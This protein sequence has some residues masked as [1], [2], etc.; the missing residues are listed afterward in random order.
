VNLNARSGRGSNDAAMQVLKPGTKITV[1]KRAGSWA[2]IRTTE[3][4]LLCSTAI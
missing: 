3:G 4:L 1:V 2:Q